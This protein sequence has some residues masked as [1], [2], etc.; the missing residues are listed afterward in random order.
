MS[1]VAE[2]VSDFFNL[3]HCNLEHFLGHGQNRSCLGAVVDTLT[4]PTGLTQV[5]C[6]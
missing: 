5:K 2:M 3:L 1:F 6:V 4:A